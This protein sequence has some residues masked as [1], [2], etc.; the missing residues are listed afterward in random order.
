MVGSNPDY[1]ESLPIRISSGSDIRN[2]TYLEITLA[3]GTTALSYLQDGDG[4]AL[5]KDAVSWLYDTTKPMMTGLEVGD[6]IL[7][8][9]EDEYRT[10]KKVPNTTTPLEY[11]GGKSAS[12]DNVGTVTV[13][14]YNGIVRGEGLNIEASI[15]NGSVTSLSWNKRDYTKNPTAS[16]YNLSLIHI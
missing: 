9:G 6:K 11:R 16:Q 7:I 10:I 2:S 15:T 3:S 4:R 5:R 1:D 12:N 14:N 8:D 13:T